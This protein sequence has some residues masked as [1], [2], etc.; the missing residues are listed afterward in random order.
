[1]SFIN[2]ARTSEVD[3]QSGGLQE[4]RRVEREAR[5]GL[6]QQSQSQAAAKVVTKGSWVGDGCD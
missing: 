5:L 3:W 2:G 6:T 4:E 1:M